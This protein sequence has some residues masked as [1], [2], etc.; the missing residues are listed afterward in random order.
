MITTRVVLSQ[1]AQIF[2]PLGFISPVLVVAKILMQIIWL[3]KLGWDDELN[4]E[5]L[6]Q[7]TNFI[8]HIHEFSQLLIP[9]H[10]FLKKL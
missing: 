4:S 1:I 2:D 9:R 6:H 10:I 3:S 5:L 7:W 8:S